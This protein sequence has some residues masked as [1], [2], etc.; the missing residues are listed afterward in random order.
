[1]LSHL[2]EHSY[3]DAIREAG[4]RP[5]GRRRSFRRASRRVSRCVIRDDRILPKIEI[6]DPAGLPGNEPRRQVAEQDVDR[7]VE[8]LRESL[9][10]LRPVEGRDEARNAIFVSID[11]ATRSAA[12]RCRNGQQEKS[13]IE[14]AWR[15]PGGDRARA[16]RNESRRTEGGRRRFSEG[17]FRR[18]PWRADGPFRSRAS[19]NS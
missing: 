2:I 9:A 17:A 11:Y 13:L 3:S 5:V 1:V 6:T 16:R 18:L 12:S 19:W 4:L 10:E 15:D 8:Q 14:L 7:A